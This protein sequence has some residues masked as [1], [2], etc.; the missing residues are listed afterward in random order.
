[1]VR[2]VLQDVLQRCAPAS[3]RVCLCVSVRVGMRVRVITHASESV[4]ELE[5][6]CAV[7]F[8]PI[9]VNKRVINNDRGPFVS[10]CVS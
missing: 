5:C 8:P 7:Y 3:A 2:R 10:K 1:M 9:E 4:R 6:V